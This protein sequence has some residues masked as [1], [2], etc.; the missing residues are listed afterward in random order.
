[1]ITITPNFVDGAFEQEV[2]KLVPYVPQRGEHRNQ[3]LRYGEHNEA[4]H[5]MVSDKIPDVFLPL[6]DKLSFDSVTINEYYPNQSIP[7]H[8]DFK[9]IGK[10][11]SIISLLS[12]AD[13]HFLYGKEKQTYRLPRFSFVQFSGDLRY[14]WK[15]RVVARDKRYSVVFRDSTDN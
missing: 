2:L 8:I 6:K 5:K 1:M 12:D 7:W 10:T 13:I 11:I 3:V 4:Y 9:D 14:K 15:H